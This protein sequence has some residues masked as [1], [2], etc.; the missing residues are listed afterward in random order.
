MANEIEYGELNVRFLNKLKNLKISHERITIR[1]I[2]WHDRMICLLGARGC[3]KTTLLLSYIKNHLPLNGTVLYVSMDDLF[4]STHNLLSFAEDFVAKGGKYLFLDEVHKYPNWS[5]ELKNIYDTLP[6]LKVVLTGS[7]ILEIHKGEADLSRRVVKYD[8]AGLSFREFF[9]LETGLTLA[10]LTLEDILYKHSEISLYISEH[11]K[12]LAL[13]A[14]YLKFGYYPFFLENK[15]TYHEKLANT[16]N[17]T[18]ETDLP[19]VHPIEFAN[20]IK[21]KKLL[22]FL[23]TTGPYKPDIVKLSGQIE[24]SRNTML[25]FLTYLK[26]AGLVHLLRDAD[27]GESIFTKPE[28]VYLHNTNLAYALGANTADTGMLREVFFLNQVSSL[29]PVHHAKVGDFKVAGKYLFEIGGKNKTFDQIKHE[30]NSFL[31]VDGIE[32][33]FKNRIPLWMFGLLY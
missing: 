25:H 11:S 17:L 22:W 29:Y 30:E 31:A 5:L 7:S 23:C 1:P 8:L 33:G 2:D 20:T 12:P 3:G 4:F 26:E 27:K 18:L 15:R 16:V 24:V 19:A 28:K 10:P 9:V 14:D 21:L 13:F 32:H 6:E